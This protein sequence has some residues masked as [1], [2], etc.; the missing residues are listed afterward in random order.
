MIL[1]II[2]HCLDKMSQQ[3]YN[4]CWTEFDLSKGWI[5]KDGIPGV[6][7]ICWGIETCP[8]TGKVHMQGYLELEKKKTFCGVK[9][10]MG[11]QTVHL[12]KRHG[13]Q[14]QAIDYCK[15][16]GQFYELGKKKAQGG[17]S[18]LVDVRLVA[19]SGGMRAV[20]METKEG[21]E[22]GSTQPR[23]GMQAIRVAETFLKYCNTP[24]DWKPV[25]IWLYGESGAGKSREARIILAGIDTHVKNTDN[26][27]WDG[28]DGQEGVILDDFRESWW[29][30]VHML[31]LLDR[32]AFQ[33][34]HKGGTRQFRAKYIVITSIRP[35][36]EYYQMENEPNKQLLRRID[37][38][39]K[40]EAP[41]NLER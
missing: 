12:E 35:P 36:Q 10:M 18:D 31:G 41:R 11:S 3:V 6:N 1:K 14:D 33:I 26:K 22:D 23:F 9:K 38:I 30:M 8:D 16:D 25:V 2:F 27:W 37:E 34:E 39:I 32:Y 5:W 24:R 20:C 19:N 15:K 13:T 4:V 21:D 28:Y 40:I 17:R 29:S 7:Y